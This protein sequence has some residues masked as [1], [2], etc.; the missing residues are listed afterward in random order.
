[1]NYKVSRRLIFKWHKPLLEGRESLEDDPRIDR[2][3]N[4]RW[5]NLAESLMDAHKNKGA[6]QHQE[7]EM[8]S[9]RAREGIYPSRKGFRGMSPEKMLG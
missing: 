5:H 2:P 1:M 9:G 4:V 8:T 3:G 6:A 7:M